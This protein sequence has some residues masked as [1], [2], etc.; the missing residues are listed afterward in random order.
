MSVT[1]AGM[2]WIN[3]LLALSTARRPRPA[4]Y[5]V[6]SVCPEL[7]MVTAAFPAIREEAIALANERDRLPTYNEVDSAQSRIAG[8]T[9][10]RW[11]VFFLDIFGHKPE[12]NRGKCPQ[13]CKAIEGIP[14]MLQAFFSI[15]DPSKSIPEHEGPYLGYLRY[16]LGL[17]VPKDNPPTITVNG[18]TYAWK[19]GEAIL[20]DDGYPHRVDNQASEVR[21]VLIIDIRRPLPFFA[22]LVNRMVTD[23]IARWTY[24]YGI[25][26]KIT[27]EQAMA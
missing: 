10:Q 21:I 9:P 14:N 13:T 23:V 20:F 27:A 12:K 6:A 17:V 18:E 5:D 15:L 24:A 1:R 19:E 11:S 8:S 25:Y 26:R 3:R 4:Y 16:H 2:Q 7:Q 22:D